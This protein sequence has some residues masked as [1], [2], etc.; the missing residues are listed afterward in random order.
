MRSAGFPTPCSTRIV[1]VPDHTQDTINAIVPQFVQT[2]S[3]IVTDGAGGFGRLGEHGY[4]HE[5]KPTRHLP[6]GAEPFPLVRTLISNAKA[7]IAGT[8]HGI[9]DRY[10]QAYLFEFCFRYCRRRRHDELFDRLLFSCLND[11]PVTLAE[12]AA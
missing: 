9:P 12:I 8:F 3:T 1:V 4:T 2:G 7:W 11:R 5:V 10:K 6:E